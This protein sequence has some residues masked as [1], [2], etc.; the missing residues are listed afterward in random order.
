MLRRSLVSGMTVLIALV[1]G[2]GTG[3][4][5]ASSTATEHATRDAFDAAKDGFWYEPA[6]R[7]V[8]VKVAPGGSKRLVEVL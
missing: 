1:S 8:W 4:D 6:S 7:S 3:T 2:C 5:E